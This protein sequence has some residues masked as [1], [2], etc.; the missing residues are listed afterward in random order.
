MP[1]KVEERTREARDVLSDIEKLGGAIAA[2]EMGYMKAQ[3]V[4]SNSRRVDAIE[5]GDQI[6]VGVNKFIET[7]PSP[8]VAGNGAIMTVSVEVEA[9]QIASLNAWRAMRDE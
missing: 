5:G 1:A 7:E 2:V 4:E 8:L 6:V 9:Q 3:L